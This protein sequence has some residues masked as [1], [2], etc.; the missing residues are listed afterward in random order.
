MAY[1]YRRSS[2]RFY[3]RIRVPEA[4][5]PHFRTQELRR[6]LQTTDR[7]LACRLALAAALE[8]KAE[9]ARLNG[10]MDLVKLSAGSPLLWSSGLVKLADVA[11]EIGLSVGELFRQ[12]KAC[13]LGL[14]VQVNGLM[15]AEVPELI[16]DDPTG[17]V[18]DIS[19]TLSGHSLKPIV[20]VLRVRPAAVVVANEDVFMDCAF[21]NGKGRPV[22]LDWPGL[23]IPVGDLLAQSA[24][25]EKVR[26]QL[27]A[28]I[29]PAMLKATQPAQP[30]SADVIEA[31]REAAEATALRVAMGEAY[32]HKGVR[33]SAMLAAYYGE[34]S[35]APATADQNRRLH[36]LFIELMNDPV[37]GDIDRAMVRQFKELAATVPH[38]FNRIRSEVKKYQGLGIHQL[39]A[40]GHADGLPLMGPERADR[41][42]AKIGEAFK[43]AAKNGYMRDNPAHEQAISLKPSERVRAQDKR[44]LFDASMLAR[45]FEQD[46]WHNGR[47]SLST[48]GK[49][50]T[51]PFKY[52]LP[53]LALYS[54]ARLNELAQLYLKDV[55]QTTAGIWYL[56]FNLDGGGKI[57]SDKRLKTFNAK[58]VVA[59]HPELVR[60]GLTDYVNA[61]RDAGHERLFPE[62]PHNRL[63]GYGKY[64]GQWFNEHFLGKKL[65]I[66][67]NGTLSFHSFRHTFLTACDRINMPDRMRDELAGHGRGD[68]TGHATY[69]KDRSADEQISIL[70]K[71]RFALP[72]IAT[73]DIRE[74][75]NALNDALE[76]RG[77]QAPQGQ[78]G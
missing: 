40:A 78:D 25:C 37:L 44:E 5:K 17:P 77:M 52:W 49:S 3:A 65:K 27:A 59:L 50:K 75:I 58:R 68:G 35:W 72:C 54:G 41:F 30:T 7:A 19:E 26:K 6:S 24:D 20:G 53:L 76:A 13:N 57:D 4:L 15:G 11:P 56:D 33:C 34:K 12:F 63:K 9:F 71:V 32:K 74:G 43:W 51:A 38:N 45:I 36:G 48:N 47:S 16:F 69:I 14:C 61:L 39:I 2:G 18:V 42:V 8:W 29:T 21:Y 66:E 1:F 28:A 64:A 31:V 46:W 70:E 62:L 55:R 22:V 67:R 23:E 60:L 73:F 10:D